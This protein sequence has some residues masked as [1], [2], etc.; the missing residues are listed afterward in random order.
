MSDSAFSQ[1]LDL[2]PVTC[3][4]RFNVGLT[5][6]MKEEK[7]N[8]NFGMHSSFSGPGIVVASE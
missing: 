1:Q 3:I 8:V 2:I 7:K 5:A 6:A 4:T